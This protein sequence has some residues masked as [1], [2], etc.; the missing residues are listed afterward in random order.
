MC[1]VWSVSKASGCDTKQRQSTYVIERQGTEQQKSKRAK[2]GRM[3]ILKNIR[4]SKVKPVMLRIVPAKFCDM[5]SRRSFKKTIFCGL[6]EAE[7][8]A[9]LALCQPCN[10]HSKQTFP[11]RSPR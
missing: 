5:L 10:D 3:E 8:N 4:L 2:K 1:G 6:C 7:H 9:T 11:K